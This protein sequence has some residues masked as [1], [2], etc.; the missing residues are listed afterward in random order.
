L[1]KSSGSDVRSSIWVLFSVRDCLKINSGFSEVMAF[2]TSCLFVLNWRSASLLSPS[3]VSISFPISEEN[4]LSSILKLMIGFSRRFEW[5]LS[6]ICI[7]CRRY[8]MNSGVISISFIGICW[9]CWFG[10]LEIVNP[11]RGFEMIDFCWSEKSV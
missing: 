10:L 9:G 6:S 2:M 4:V 3:V 11:V 5:R 1:E 8:D 7:S